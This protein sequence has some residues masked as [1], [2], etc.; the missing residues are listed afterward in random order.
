MTLSR[1]QQQAIRVRRARRTRSRLHGTAARPRFSVNRSLK[2]ISAQLIDDDAGVTL[3]SASDQ[4]M[5]DKKTKSERAAFVGSE[6][7]KLAQEKG[8][9]EVVF[10]RGAFRYHGR[11]RTLAEAARE[12]GLKF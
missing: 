9:T 7:A 5:K 11:V 8:V 10:D 12:A 1:K 6:L 2:H 3:C 4:S